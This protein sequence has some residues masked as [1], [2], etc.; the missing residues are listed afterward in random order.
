MAGAMDHGDESGMFEWIQV[1]LFVLISILSFIAF[2]MLSQR[3]IPKAPTNAKSVSTDDPAPVEENAD[4]DLPYV[5]VDTV[6]TVHPEACIGAGVCFNDRSGHL[7]MC[8]G[9]TRNDMASGVHM[10][11]TE[12][13]SWGHYEDEE[14][15]GKRLMY[16]NL[17]LMRGLLVRYGGMDEQSSCLDGVWCFD[18]AALRWVDAE[19]S[20]NV[21]DGEYPP[22]RF[23]ATFTL[24]DE[25]SAL[26]VGGRTG[27]SG[28]RST[29]LGDVWLLRL[30]EE[31]AMDFAWTCLSHGDS[32]FR[33][34]EGH[35]TAVLNG[36]AF[37]LGGALLDRHGGDAAVYNDDAV[38]MF[39]LE[40]REWT[41]IPVLGK[42]PLGAIEGGGAHAV[43]SANNIVVLSTDTEG[44]F[45]SVYILHVG[46][47]PGP[48]RPAQWTR[49]QV[50]WGGDWSMIPGVRLYP[51]SA[52][53]SRSGLLYVFGG[54]GGENVPKQGMD[55]ADVSDWVPDRAND[56]DA[57]EGERVRED[58]GGGQHS[59]APLPSKIHSGG[60]PRSAEELFANAAKFSQMR[61]RGELFSDD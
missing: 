13:R 2:H 24:V 39:D 30:G 19:A 14:G 42:G 31:E 1:G 8:G 21:G 27:G 41:S 55:I 20:A 47:A 45:N 22:S 52:L 61:T 44:V 26:L 16:S 7:L 9:A 48:S 29:C 15:H 51:A 11:S 23:N 50:C 3:T 5:V 36:C 57:D 46:E 60:I 12:E 38:E 10:Y 54:H 56:A 40:K 49:T 28:S 17:A 37:V 18:F 58:V 59:S 53:D 35:S 33:A 25:G 32:R 4:P 6:H 43:P 34:R